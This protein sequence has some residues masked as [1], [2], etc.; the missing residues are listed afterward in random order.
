M[1]NNLFKFDDKLNDF[2]KIGFALSGGL[3][4]ALLLYYLIKYTNYEITC[5]TCFE[6][7]NPTNIQPA[8]EIVQLISKK[9]N[10]NIKNH[11]FK[12]N[13]FVLEKYGFQ[14]NHYFSRKYF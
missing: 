4:S 8:K 3:D 14:E 11:I 7:I 6:D 1:T 12:E 5:I 9:I 13:S 2:K 10:K